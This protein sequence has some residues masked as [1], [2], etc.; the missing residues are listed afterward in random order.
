MTG[1]LLRQLNVGQR[2]DQTAVFSSR[3]FFLEA[4][5]CAEGEDLKGS[6]KSTRCRAQRDRSLPVKDNQF[7]LRSL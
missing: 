2:V 3:N 4:Q 6:L 5:R 1:G 7:Q